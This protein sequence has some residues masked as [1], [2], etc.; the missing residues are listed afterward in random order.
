MAA[1]T[2]LDQICVVTAGELITGAHHPDRVGHPVGEVVEPRA[3]ARSQCHV[4]DCGLAQHPGAR[5]A[6]GLRIV[7]RDVFAAAETERKP[8]PDRRLD[9]WCVEIYVVEAK[10]RRS[11]VEVEALML[12]LKLLDRMKELKRIPERIPDT[13]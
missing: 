3:R 11:A 13:H 1:W 7:G 4:V 8:E 12:S 10:D 5:D 9:S 2:A 6:L